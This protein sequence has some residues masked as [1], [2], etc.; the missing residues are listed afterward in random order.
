M[1]HA[2]AYGEDEDEINQWLSITAPK[3]NIDPEKWWLEDDHFPIGWNG[4]FSG[5]NCWTSGG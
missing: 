3:F 5:A 1:D 2:I 4:N